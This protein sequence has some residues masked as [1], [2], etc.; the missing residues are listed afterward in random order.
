MGRAKTS[1]TLE[2]LNLMKAVSL[3]GA[4]KLLGSRL[5]AAKTTRETQTLLGLIDSVGMDRLAVAVFGG[6]SAASK[7]GISERVTEMFKWA[8][9]FFN[10]AGRLCATGDF[11]LNDLTSVEGLVLPQT[12][13]GDLDLRSLTTAGDGRVILPRTVRGDLRLNRLTSAKGVVMP[14]RV[15]GC[16]DLESLASADGLVLPER[17]GC[18]LHLV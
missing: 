2:A 5:S 10:K 14:K 8:K 1:I 4:A 11:Y 18:D 17:V 15:G 16:V 13:S 7:L 12:I 9:P 6:A 3:E